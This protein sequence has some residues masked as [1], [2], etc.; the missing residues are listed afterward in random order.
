MEKYASKKTDGNKKGNAVEG[1]L[2][3]EVGVSRFTRTQ[4]WGALPLF[5]V[6]MPLQ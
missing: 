1:N 4:W 2:G 3:V 5:I 6:K